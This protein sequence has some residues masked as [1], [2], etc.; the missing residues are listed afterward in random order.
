M[1]L[2][3]MLTADI[4]GGIAN[5]TQRPVLYLLAS[6]FT[7]AE[8]ITVEDFS[9]WTELDDY[10]INHISN[11]YGTGDNVYGPNDGIQVLEVGATPTAYTSAYTITTPPAGWTDP[12]DPAWAAPSTGYGSKSLLTSNCNLLMKSTSTDPIPVYTPAPLWKPQG[13]YDKH[14]WGSF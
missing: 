11:V 9:V 6:D 8:N 5:G 14:Y 10:V 2:Q 13:D 1:F 7:P 3:A 12:P 4:L